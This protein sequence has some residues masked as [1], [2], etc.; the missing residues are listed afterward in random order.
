MPIFEY[1]CQRCRAEFEELHLSDDEAS[2]TCRRCGSL[3]VERLLSSFAVRT[4]VA[5]IASDSGPCG[6]CGAPQRGMC[7]A[8]RG[9]W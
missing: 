5:S 2:T 7:A 3:R 9:E 8:E 1:R 4:G 6:A